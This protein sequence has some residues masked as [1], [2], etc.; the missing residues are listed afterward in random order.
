LKKGHKTKQ[1]RLVLKIKDPKK[2]NRIDIINEILNIMRLR[3]TLTERV[4]YHKIK[5]SASCM[6]KQAIKNKKGLIERDFSIKKNNLLLMTDTDLLMHLSRNDAISNNLIEMIQKKNLYKPCLIISFQYAQKIGLYGRLVRD[7]YL[8]DDA[9]KNVLTLEEQL[10]NEIKSIGHN[11]FISCS[12]PKMQA[13]EIDTYIQLEDDRI[14]AMKLQRQIDPIY[15]EINALTEKYKNLWRFYIFLHPDDI[16]NE[17][18]RHKVIDK[19]CDI[20]GMQPDEAYKIALYDSNEPQG[21][22]ISILNEWKRDH[23]PPWITDLHYYQLKEIIN[24][25]NE[26]AKKINPRNPLLTKSN[27]FEQFEEIIIR[28]EI[29]SFKTEYLNENKQVDENNI[30]TYCENQISGF[31]ENPKKYSQKLMGKTRPKPNNYDLF[32]AEFEKLLK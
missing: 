30:D 22:V 28:N 10:T 18:I 9:E 15:R 31:L 8:H 21:L 6:M 5:M 24:N 19:F 17:I 26:W 13:K 3:Y 1:L 4:L 29:T 25:G 23:A 2:Q 20:L 27:Y 12:N 11:V 32:K 14:V 16:K 7:Y